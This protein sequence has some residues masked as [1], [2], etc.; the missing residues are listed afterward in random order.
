MNISVNSVDK[1]S[2]KSIACFDLH[3]DSVDKQE[4]LLNTQ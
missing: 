1:P 2:F 4:T 3:I